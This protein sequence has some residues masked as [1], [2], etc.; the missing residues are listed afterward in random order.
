MS[1]DP[2]F[3]EAKLADIAELM[4]EDLGVLVDAFRSSGAEQVSRI[5]AANSAG[6][7]GQLIEA[8]HQLKGSSANL[9]ADTLSRHCEALER[10]IRGSGKTGVDPA[11]NRI[12]QIFSDTLAEL[13]RRFDTP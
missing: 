12:A 9:G 2:L 8:L 7:A 4:G 1:D 5:R 3:D 6:N 13:G 11:V 10:A